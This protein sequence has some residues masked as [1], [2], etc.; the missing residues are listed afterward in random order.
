MNNYHFYVVSCYIRN[1]LDKKVQMKGNSV[2]NKYFWIWSVVSIVIFIGYTQIPAWYGL[3]GSL[4]MF[5]IAL[6]N[7]L[8]RLF[9]IYMLTFIVTFISSILALLLQLI[10]NIQYHD[11]IGYILIVVIITLVAYIGLAFIRKF[12]SLNK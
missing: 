8:P 5:F 10:A 12:K 11:S 7:F 2:F 4:L 6:S 9:K 1:Q 3:V